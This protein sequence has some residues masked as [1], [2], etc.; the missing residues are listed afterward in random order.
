MALHLVERLLA[1]EGALVERDGELAHVV[2]PGELQ[3]A[4]ELPELATLD[5]AGVSGAACGYGSELLRRAVDRSLARG[6]VAAAVARVDPPRAGTPPHTGLNVALRPGSPAGLTTWTLVGH[7]L[8]DARADDRREA[9][10]SAAVCLLSGAPMPPPIG[11][12]LLDTEERPD[13]GLLREAEDR[14]LRD[15]RRAALGALAP[16]RAAV[17]R[18]H[19]RDV[20]RVDRYFEELDQDLEARS[21]R[22]KGASLAGKRATLPAERERRLRAL[23]EGHTVHVALNPIALLLVR[24]PVAE[25]PLTVLR[26]KRSRVVSTLYDGLARRW[27][28]LV[29]EGCCEPVMAFGACDD[30]VHVLCGRCV[31]EKACPACA[32]RREPLSRVLAGAT[33]AVPAGTPGATPRTA[34]GPAGVDVRGGAGSGM[35][36]ETTPSAGLFGGGRNGGGG[37]GVW[38][39]DAAGRAVSQGDGA[40]REASRSGSAGRAPTRGEVTPGTSSTAR[41]TTAAPTAARLPPLRPPPT[42]SAGPMYPATAPGGSAVADSIVGVLQSGD[43]WRAE[44]LRHMTGASSELLRQVLQDLIARGLVEKGGQARGTWYRWVG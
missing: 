2:L 12:D 25:V 32:G 16:F 8:V 40:G 17:A 37:R 24:H 19:R 7:F 21:Q 13:G 5:P 6:A 29:C 15:A 18:R 23:A 31:T 3:A 34:A 4:Y 42:T 44:Q 10:V 39:S 30:E 33:E 28:P 41:S 27:Q 43:P 26:R 36:S 38:G 35:E 14:L 9:V 11:I 1:A 22:S 20:L